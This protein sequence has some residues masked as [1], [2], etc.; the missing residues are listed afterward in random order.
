MTVLSWAG[1]E[2]GGR[3]WVWGEDERR[4]RRGLVK[5]RETKG[6]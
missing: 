3:P 5:E 2:G 6:K 1:E 4:I